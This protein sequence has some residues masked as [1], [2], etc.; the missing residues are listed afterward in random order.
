MKKRFDR[1]NLIRNWDQAALADATVVILGIGALGNEVARILAMSGVGALILCDPDTVEETNLSRA[2]LFG[3]SDVGRPK[4]EAAS[5]ALSRLA[6]TTSVVCRHLP[7]VSGVGLAEL[8]DAS[9]V[10]SCL[11][12]RSARLQLA[13][14]CCLVSARWIDGG[15]HAWGGEVR[16]YLDPEG[17]CYGCGLTTGE[18][19]TVDAPWSCFNLVQDSPAA[20][21]TPVSA[22]VGAWMSTLALRV[23]M[24]VPCSNSLLR[25]DAARATMAHVDLGRDP[26]CPLHSRAGSV[27]RMP[28]TANDTVGL[29]RKE[30]SSSDTPLLWEATVRSVLCPKCNFFEE[31]WGRASKTLRCPN[32]GATMRP[33]TTLELDRAPEHL[34]LA[35]LGVAPREILAVRKDDGDFTWIELSC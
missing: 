32:C 8:R 20:A 34:S 31:R 2:V 21:S 23:L 22:L 4:V 33:S 17:P 18:R 27:K 25:I 11:D 3:E 28:V 24:G 15:T 35:S 7:L 12:T 13:G 6:P 10:M 5:S 30:L 19:A 14:R 29:L 16:P 1:H 26:E 9:L